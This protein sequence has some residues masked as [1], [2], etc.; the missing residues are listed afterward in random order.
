VLLQATA[1]SYSELANA[2][3]QHQQQAQQLAAAQQVLQPD[4]QGV[5]VLDARGQHSSSQ[6]GTQDRA[7]CWL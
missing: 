2:L 7:E 1:R 6:V 3:Q 4:Q 5:P